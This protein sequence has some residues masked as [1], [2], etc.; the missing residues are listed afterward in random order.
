M[1]DDQF[2]RSTNT[3]EISKMSYQKPRINLMDSVADVVFKMS[4]G[5][6]G[7]VNVLV[8]LL[9]D[10][11]AIDP[12]DFVGG[13]GVIL[14]LDTHDIYG[15][16]IWI[17]FKDVSGSDLVTMCA[18]LRGVQLGYLSESELVSAISNHKMEAARIQEIV[19]KVK[20]RLPKFGRIEIA[21]AAAA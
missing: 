14:S 1:P 19:Q 5:N 10:G 3:R 21:Q 13:L 4:D 6:P 2:Q 9:K 17:L 7:A 8:R 20:D 16:H 11:A 12:D 18:L 15:S